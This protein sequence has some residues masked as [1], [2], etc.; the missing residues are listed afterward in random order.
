MTRPLPAAQTPRTALAAAVE[1]YGPEK[2]ATLMFTSQYDAPHGSDVWGGT[3]H[4]QSDPKQKQ[5]R[6]LAEVLKQRD[7]TATPTGSVRPGS[8]RG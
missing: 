4:D 6:R 2:V 8:P 3:G 7:V 1:L 5:S